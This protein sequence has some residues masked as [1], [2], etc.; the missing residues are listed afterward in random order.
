M[1][2]ILKFRRNLPLLIIVFAAFLLRLPHLGHSGMSFF[3][4]SF[5]ALVARNL[6]KHPLK[7][8]LIDDPKVPYDPTCWTEN[9]VWLH[10]PIVPLWQ[11]ALSYRVLGVNN[12]ALR[13]PSL[14]LSTGAVLLT[15][16]IGTSLFERRTGLIA[17]A[18][19]ALNP[20][21][22]LLVQGYLF[23]DHIDV[24]LL[25]WVEMGVYFLVRAMKSGSWRDVLLAGVAQGLAYLSKSHLAAIITGLAVAAWL[26]PLVRLG[27]AEE[28][29]IRFPHVIVLFA[30]A[31]AT[32]APWTIYCL[33]HYPREFLSEQR[34]VFEHMTR[35][36]ETWGGPWDRVLFDHMIL[37][38]NVFY[39]PVLVAALGLLGKTLSDRSTSL[40]LIYAWAL[41]VVVPFLAARTKTPSATLLAVPAFLLLLARLISLAWAGGRWPL[42]VWTA[43][44]LVCVLFPGRIRPCGH[45][46]PDPPV[47]AG[48]MRQSLWVVYH[49]AAALGI[50]VALRAWLAGAG[51]FDR[52]RA[53]RVIAVAGTIALAVQCVSASLRSTAIKRAHANFQTMA[54]FVH[55]TLPREAV[56]LFD[57]PDAGDHHALMMAADR[58][59]YSLRGRTESALA[60]HVLKRG[61]VPFI[62]SATARSGH[63]L[64]K[65]ADL[66]RAIYAWTEE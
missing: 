8:T 61:G 3:D 51:V 32:A 39:T 11:I 10:K 21:I 50:A 41:G 12:F 7:P 42:A 40:W 5:H 66:G 31:L 63:P 43:I 6:L 55:D 27:R 2:A 33:V 54:A 56:F 48:V 26:L 46:F 9:H 58:P 25:F 60:N 18:L 65:S 52:A 49:V 53:A 20:A 22:T 16:L 36:V 45:G 13:L 30:A 38:Y 23:A 28:S 17:A 4:E 35:A 15:F 47:F 34:Y 64:Y 14:L 44:V 37:L 24:A 19:Q 1:N 62:V 59:C 57:G 29:R